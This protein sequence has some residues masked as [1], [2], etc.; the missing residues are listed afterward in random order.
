[1]SA[2]GFSPAVV[3]QI[4]G[5]AGAIDGIGAVCEI[6][7]AGAVAER[8]HRRPRGSGGTNRESTN[9]AANGLGLCR[10]CHR[11]V[12]KHR[13]VAGILGWLVDQNLDPANTRVMRRGEWVYLDE[14]GG[15]EYYDQAGNA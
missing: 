9:T 1:M 6:C 2:T 12:E 7:G 14:H 5:R 4:D 8:H 13:T 15:F 10:E 11:M 3:D